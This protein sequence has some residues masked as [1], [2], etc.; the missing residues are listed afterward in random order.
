MKTKG[1]L[2]FGLAVVF[3]A[4]YSCS[5]VKVV[6]DYDKEAD[7]S[8]YETFEYYGWSEGSGSLL[9]E[10]DK[11]RIEQAFGSEFAR[12]DL[13]FLKSDG[14]L[15]V[16]LVVILDQK[17]SKTAYTNHYGGGLYSG[18]YGFGG[19]WGMGSSTTTIQE[20]EYVD[21]TLIIDVF[22]TKSKKLVWQGVATGTVDD[23]P[24]TREKNIPKVV[25]QIMEQFPIKPQI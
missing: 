18:Y 3:A 2:V 9:N 8:Q 4:L 15:A 19:G 22:D 1:L 7:F 12:R 10:F 25:E 5:G 20:Y 17:T 6:S 16:S 13:K 24:A 23:N 14:D 11:N 21:G